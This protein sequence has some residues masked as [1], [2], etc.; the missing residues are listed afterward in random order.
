MRLYILAAI[1]GVMNGEIM[2]FILP[3]NTRGYVILYMAE[4]QVKD[5]VSKLCKKQACA[6]QFCLQGT[7]FA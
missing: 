3:G 5:F 4:G 1:R 2:I 7:G 6:I